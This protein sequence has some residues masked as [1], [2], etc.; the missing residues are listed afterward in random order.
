MKTKNTAMKTSILF[1]LLIASFAIF[2][3]NAFG[4][5]VSVS[6]DTLVLPGAFTQ[7]DELFLFKNNTSCVS[8]P[9]HNVCKATAAN[10]KPS[11]YSLIGANFCSVNI[12][13]SRLK[14]SMMVARIH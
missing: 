1:V 2:G 13:E 8:C 12:A 4:Q 11:A 3:S 14:K 6:S 7:A 10:S 5:N 9:F